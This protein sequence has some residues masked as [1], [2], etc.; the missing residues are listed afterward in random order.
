MPSPTEVS[1]HADG[2]ARPADA[3]L[4]ICILKFP[5]SWAPPRKKRG[6]REAYTTKQVTRKD[7]RFRF[8]SHTHT[9]T[10]Y[11][12][13]TT[14]II[15]VRFIAPAESRIAR[16]ESCSY[17][18]PSLVFLMDRKVMELAISVLLCLSVCVFNVCLGLKAASNRTNAVH[19]PIQFA[20]RCFDVMECPQKAKHNRFFNNQLQLHR[21]K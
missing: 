17:S 8:S 10:S 13:H 21:K 3:T 18:H 9:Q 7:V 12:T 5:G 11:R 4:L 6:T 15:K 2:A 1:E 19:V 20:T 14:R 16:V